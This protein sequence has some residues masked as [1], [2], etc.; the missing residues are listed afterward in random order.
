[1]FRSLVLWTATICL[2]SKTTNE[3]QWSIDFKSWT[4]A[5]ATHAW[6]AAQDTQFSQTTTTQLHTHTARSLRLTKVFLIILLLQK[7]KP[8]QISKWNWQTS[9]PHS[10]TAWTS[11]KHLWNRLPKSCNFQWG[12]SLLR[13]LTS[14]RAA[15]NWRYFFI[16]VVWSTTV[17][18]CAETNAILEQERSA[19][20][21]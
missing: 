21:T 7:S 13:V 1:M 16:K 17:G 11:P 10:S 14:V 4:T 2:A 5:N 18:P 6:I 9:L 3:R 15:T 12:K 19:F 8:K 20:S